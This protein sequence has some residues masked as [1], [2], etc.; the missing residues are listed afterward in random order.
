MGFDLS[1]RLDLEQCIVRL[2]FVTC[3]DEIKILGHIICLNDEQSAKRNWS[4]ALKKSYSIVNKISSL[5]LDTRSKVLVIKSF[6]LAQLCYTSRCFKPCNETIAKIEDLICNFINYGRDN[7]SRTNIFTPLDGLGLGIPKIEDYCLSQL[8]KNC[9]RALQSDQPWAQLLKANFK[10]GLFDRFRYRII[11]SSYMNIM[12][13]AMSNMATLYYLSSNYEAPLF[14]NK[15]VTNKVDPMVFNENP[16]KPI[17][18][19]NSPSL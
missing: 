14:Y 19:I 12:A 9:S 3:V 8:Q 5:F 4:V 6:V 15:Y 18:V 16:P 10:F 11:G 1:D 7:F 17:N 2:G 13:D